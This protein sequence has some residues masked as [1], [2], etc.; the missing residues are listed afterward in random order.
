MDKKEGRSR[1]WCRCWCC[2]CWCWWGA[3]ICSWLFLL[4]TGGCRLKCAPVCRGL[5]NI[6][7]WTRANLSQRLGRGCAENI[8]SLAALLKNGRAAFQWPGRAT[9]NRWKTKQSRGRKVRTT[10]R[11]RSQRHPSLSRREFPWSQC[12]LPIKEGRGSFF[13]RCVSA[14]N[15]RQRQKE[16]ETKGMKAERKRNFKSWK[17]GSFCTPMLAFVAVCF[18]TVAAYSNF[19]SCWGEITMRTHQL[20]FYYLITAS[21]GSTTVISTQLHFALIGICGC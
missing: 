6:W 18:Q 12:S 16:E 4:E 7:G 14:C 15:I 9:G 21:P 1:C 13:T 19:R 3:V 10:V 8:N 20:C 11:Q 2:C 5:C 17:I